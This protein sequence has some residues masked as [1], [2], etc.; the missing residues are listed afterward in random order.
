MD[1]N[2][3]TAYDN[4]ISSINWI[5]HEDLKEIFSK[6]EWFNNDTFDNENNIDYY[7]FFGTEIGAVRHQG[8]IPWDDDI[9][10]AMLREDFVKFKA[11][12]KDKLPE[13][14]RYQSF[15]NKDGYHYFFDKITIND[16]LKKGFYDLEIISIK[17]LLL[18]IYKIMT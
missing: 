14:Y 15:E 6:L 4:G 17:K 10:I 12:I 16:T 18:K 7:L 11:I 3:E 5:A 2:F 1:V 8:F 13:K 9:D